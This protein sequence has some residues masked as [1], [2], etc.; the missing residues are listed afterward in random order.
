MSLV[1]PWQPSEVKGE[2]L[3][4]MEM[5]ERCRCP[6]PYQCYEEC[7]HQ[8]LS[9]PLATAGLWWAVEFGIRERK[10]NEALGTGPN[11]GSSLSARMSADPKTSWS[12][13]ASAMDTYL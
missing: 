1:M 3:K 10:R 7:S 11:C 2:C 5:R 4:R 12:V 9:K 6:S 13:D 8:H